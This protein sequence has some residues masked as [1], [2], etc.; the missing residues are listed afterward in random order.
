MNVKLPLKPIFKDSMLNNLKTCTSRTKRHG[1]PGD[2]FDIFDET[3]E[4][5]AVETRKLEDIANHLYRFEGFAHPLGFIWKTIHSVNGYQPEQ[6]VYVHLFKKIR[7][8]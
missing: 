7:E 6:G 4:I 1:R 5:T 3:F 2:T 8:N